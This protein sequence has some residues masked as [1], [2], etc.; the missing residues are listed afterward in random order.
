MSPDLT[1]PFYLSYGALWLLIILHSLVLLGIVRIVY[2]L[3]QNDAA[4]RG[5]NLSGK[6][7]P[8]FSAEDIT[9]VPIHSTDLTGPL[10]TLLFISTTC[11]GCL[12]VLEHDMD[13]LQHRS[14]GNVIVICRDTRA[15][16][17]QLAEQ[18]KLNIPVIADEDA[19]L[20]RLYQI[21]GVPTAVVISAD[22]RIL[23]YGQ[24]QRESLAEMSNQVA[25]SN[26]KT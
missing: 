12:E 2:Q 20:S 15:S 8:A 24:V 4:T 11:A 10:K 16:C 13:Y 5:T 17:V 9:G 26:R 1:T 23:S 21:S 19:R 25:Q 3:Q 18:Y 7:A 22:D 6:Q 14:G